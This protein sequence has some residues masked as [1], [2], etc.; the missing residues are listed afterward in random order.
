MPRPFRRGLLALRHTHKIVG[1]TFE[2]PQLLLQLVTVRA[3]LHAELLSKL[4]QPQ[5]SL[6]LLSPLTLGDQTLHLA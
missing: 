2:G 3:P 5:R 6:L 1:I 4:R